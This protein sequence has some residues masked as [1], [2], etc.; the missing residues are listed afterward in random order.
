MLNMTP[1]RTQE[2][3]LVGQVQFPL[4]PNYDAFKRTIPSLLPKCIIRDAKEFDCDELP[5]KPDSDD[6]GAPG[7]D[8][9][10]PPPL[11]VSPPGSEAGDDDRE[12]GD[13]IE[14]GDDDED[15]SDGTY[16]K[17]DAI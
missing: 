17:Q 13:E 16:Y 8:Q 12:D 7:G 11:V 10:H 5:E 14:A 1:I 6:A 4:K 9:D 15:D 3:K 2:C